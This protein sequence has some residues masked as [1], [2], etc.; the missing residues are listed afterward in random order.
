MKDQ[1]KLSLMR[2][3][4]KALYYSNAYKVLEPTW[5][6]VGLIYMLHKVDPN[7]VEGFAPNRILQVRPDFLEG[8][9]QQAIDKDFDIVSLDEA[10]RRMKEKDFSRH[11]VCFTF[12][13]GYKDNLYYALPI[14]QKYNIPMAVYIPSDY[15]S[16]DGE[17]W[18]V[19]LEKVIAKHDAL[20]VTMPHTNEEGEQED[21]EHKFDCALEAGKWA[22]WRAIYQ[23]MRHEMD[24]EGQRG[25]IK[26]LC[27][28]YDVDLFQICRDEIMTWAQVREMDKDPLV[29]IAGHTVSHR[30]VGRLSAE[31]S[32]YEME[33]GLA[34][35][36]FELGH[37]VAHFSY[38]YGNEAS[39]SDRDFKLAASLGLKTAVTTRKGVLFEEHSDHPM[40]LPRVSLNG[41]YQSLEMNEVLLSGAAFA[42]FNKFQKLNVG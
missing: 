15:P 14:F 24:E 6:G 34:H 21:K 33:T 18:W 37:K 40:A 1:L 19:A 23:V 9:I 26:Q 22:T 39:A 12:D 35:L 3:S 13:D 8:I 5:Q 7:P 41:D 4:L 32:L 27:Q 30:A 17:L 25:F 10:H 16:G 38:P 31:D 2:N 29:T 11:F 42:L 36:E 20:T 28:T